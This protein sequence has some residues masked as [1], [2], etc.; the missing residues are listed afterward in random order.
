MNLLFW[1]LRRRERRIPVDCENKMD[2][3]CVV[4]WGKWRP[5]TDICDKVV[6]I[7][8]VFFK[9]C[10]CYSHSP[11]HSG[12]PSFLFQ[13]CQLKSLLTSSYQV[14]CPGGQLVTRIRFL[15]IQQWKKRRKKTEL[16]HEFRHFSHWWLGLVQE[17]GIITER[18]IRIE[19]TQK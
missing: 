4:V 11:F 7:L 9:R 5:N 19:S 6:A 14:F 15:S 12:M 3:C 10:R 16:H 17:G 2:E 8:N 18:G 13:S 1:S